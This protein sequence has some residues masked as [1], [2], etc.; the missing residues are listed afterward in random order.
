MTL[1]QVSQ[2]FLVVGGDPTLRFAP[3]GDA[4]CSFRVKASDRKFND[5]TQKWE[6]SKVLWAR[7]TC[8]KELAEHVAESVKDKDLVVVVGKIS[9][10]EYTDNNN[11]QRQSVEIDAF[12]V[13]PSLRFRTMPH[14]QGGQQGGGQQQPQDDPWGTPQQGQGQWPQG[15]QQAPPQQG[16]Q[17]PPQNW[18]QGQQ[19]PPPNQQQGPPPNQQNPYGNQQQPPYGGN[20]QGQ[21]PYGNQQQQNPYGNQGAPEF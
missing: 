5:Q 18:N 4:I 7:V 21:P 6:D 15:G 9:L 12:H 8:W 3:N 10:N 11:Q 1:P 17:G 13:G 20:Q 19:G 2:E 14:G 16:Q